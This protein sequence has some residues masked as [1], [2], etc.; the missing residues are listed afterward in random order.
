LLHAVLLTHSG[1]LNEAEIVCGELL[2]ND[3]LDAG[4]HYLLALCRESA[5][6]ARGAEEHD[7]LAAHLDPA[8][9]MPRLHLG[10]LARRRG[11]LA[12]AR[13]ELAQ[14]LELLQREDAARVLLFGGGF[15]REALVTLCR[16][17]LGASGGAP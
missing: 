3:D 4:A 6:D 17:E 13:R 15:R 10:L 11:D 7:R 12:A 5:S 2:R 14:A 8:F 1:R 16:A 9:A